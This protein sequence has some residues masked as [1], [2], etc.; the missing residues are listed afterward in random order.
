[1][2]ANNQSMTRQV[3]QDRRILEL[4]S[5]S[6][7]NAAAAST[8]IINLR[9]ILNLPKG[10]EHFICDLHG[11]N[12]AFEHVLRNGSG[13]IRQKVEMIFGD[14]LPEA[15]IRELCTLIYYPEDKIRAMRSTLRSRARMHVFAGEKESAVILRSAELLGRELP[16]STVTILPGLYHGEFSLNRPQDYAR[17]VRD[18]LH[19]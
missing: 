16:G 17:A 2:S 11:E 19:A 3:E 10:T 1:M 9:A 15:E 4:L 14:T 18:I 7:P 5:Q 8:E 12:E 13:V 6:F